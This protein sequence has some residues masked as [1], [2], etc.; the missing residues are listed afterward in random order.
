MNIF[1][2][3]GIKHLSPSAIN[4]YIADPLQYILRYL[5]KIKTPGGPAMWRGS[6]V[7]NAVGSFY[8][9]HH[10]EF[11]ARSLSQCQTDALKSMEEY[12]KQHKSDGF[13][14]DD[15][16]LDKWQQEKTLVPAYI[17]T[18]ID[19]YN[20]FDKAD[21]YQEKVMYEVKG[22]PIPIVGFLDL[23]YEKDGVVRDIKTSG[24]KVSELSYSVSRQLALYGQCTGLTPLA[25]YIVCNKSSSSVV[26]LEVKDVKGS[27]DELERGALAIMK[28]LSI[29][30]DIND[31]TSLFYPNFDDFRW[32]DMR[33]D[34]DVK[35][36]FKGEIK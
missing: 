2:Y 8:G 22:L 31:L 23:K 18:A 6:A 30:D 35:S 7:D 34:K 10:E 28:L 12:L 20:Q 19:H 27:L 24:R 11:K 13:D 1:E 5:V 17:R 29:S 3:W 32:S 14:T 25:D 9:L 21:T 33:D 36:F 15:K 26:T 4:L 16:F